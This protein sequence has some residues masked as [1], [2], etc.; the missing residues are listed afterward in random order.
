MSFDFLR[1][2]PARL[3]TLLLAGQ[4]VA[5]YSFSRPEVVPQSKPL[6]QF[7]DVLGSWKKY[8]EGVVEKEVQDVLQAVPEHLVVVRQDKA[9]FLFGHDAYLAH[10][11]PPGD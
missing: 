5:L 8:H 11:P 1:S 6:A 9:D 2:G 10:F 4:A 3:L 7:P